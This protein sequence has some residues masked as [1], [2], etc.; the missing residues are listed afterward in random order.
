MQHVPTEQ[1]LDALD[2]RGDFAIVGIQARAIVVWPRF[3]LASC[4]S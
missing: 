2:V 1:G 3:R 4:D